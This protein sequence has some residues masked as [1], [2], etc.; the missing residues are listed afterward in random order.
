MRK[1]KCEAIKGDAAVLQPMIDALNE[2]PSRVKEPG[3]QPRNSDISNVVINFLNECCSF[4]GVEFQNAM[5]IFGRSTT[6]R[7]FFDSL[8]SLDIVWYLNNET[9]DNTGWRDIINVNLTQPKPRYFEVTLPVMLRF[10]VKGYT[11]VE[12]QGI[13]KVSGSPKQPEKTMYGLTFRINMNLKYAQAQDFWTKLNPPAD[14]YFSGLDMD[15]YTREYTKITHVPFTSLF[16][17]GKEVDLFRRVNNSFKSG[18]LASLVLLANGK[19]LINGDKGVHGEGKKTEIWFNE[20]HSY[21]VVEVE[22][23]VIY[24]GKQDICPDRPRLLTLIKEE[25]DSLP[26]ADLYL[27]AEYDIQVFVYDQDNDLSYKQMATLKMTKIKNTYCGTIIK[28]QPLIPV[29]K[30][31]MLDLNRLERDNDIVKDI[32]KD[33]VDNLEL[34][35]TL[36][37][38]TKDPYFSDHILSFI[39]SARASILEDP[40]TARDFILSGY[41][42]GTRYDL[43]HIKSLKDIPVWNDFLDDLEKYDYSKSTTEEF[44]FDLNFSVMLKTLKGKE[45]VLQYVGTLSL[46]LETPIKTKLHISTKAKKTKT[47]IQRDYL[48]KGTINRY[49]DLDL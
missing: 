21:T 18:T 28:E 5:G 8:S 17:D 32:Q 34:K 37:I 22:G 36:V 20:T 40:E 41:L 3:A 43:F 46:E 7:K 12:Y 44:V 30:P 47:T 27:S 35:D 42:D 15:S 10:N 25:V 13:F 14:D 2:N 1:L 11:I 39:R 33:F 48:P 24:D 29:S 23:F 6:G 31:R 38:D 45:E 16:K 4:D 49:S 9:L 26:E 19:E